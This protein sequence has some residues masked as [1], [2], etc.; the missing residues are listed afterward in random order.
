MS[1]GY[2]EVGGADDGYSVASESVGLE[3]T[4]LSVI[5]FIGLDD[6]LKVGWSVT[7]MIG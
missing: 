5:P 4:G 3:V 7:G 1:G 6:G 2:A